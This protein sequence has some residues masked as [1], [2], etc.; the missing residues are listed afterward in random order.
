[1]AAHTKESFGYYA[2][3]TPESVVPSHTAPG[4]PPPVRLVSSKSDP[5]PEM[6]L[7]WDAPTEN[8]GSPVTGY[9]LWMDNWEG[10][11]G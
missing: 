9:E 3:S 8:G 5:G 11:L 2:I 7:E 6:T 1:M 4:A 10:T